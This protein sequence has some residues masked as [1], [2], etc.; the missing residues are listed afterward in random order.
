MIGT[1]KNRLNT[2]I[3][4]HK[5]GSKKLNVRDGIVLHRRRRLSRTRQDA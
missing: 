2:K 3:E 5:E 1:L 4:P